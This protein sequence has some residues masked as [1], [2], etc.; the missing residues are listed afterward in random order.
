M[1]AAVGLSNIQTHI[2]D[3]AYPLYPPYNAP[4]QAALINDIARWYESGVDFTKEEALKNHLAGGGVDSDFE[5][6]WSRE[7]ARRKR[8]LTAIQT[9]AY[10]CG[11]GAMSYLVSGIK[12]ETVFKGVTIQS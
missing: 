7:I 3:K 11:G 4:E 1:F 10:D 2:S 12:S 8:I 9:K 5:A 6:H